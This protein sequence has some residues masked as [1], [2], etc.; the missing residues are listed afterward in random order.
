MNQTRVFLIFAWLMVA[1]LL[2]ME[3]GK[4]N[5]PRP[6]P[7][8]TPSAQVEATPSSS[9]NVPSATAAVET[10]ASGTAIPATT[11]AATA[12]SPR[13]V[14]STDV[15]RLTLDGG[16]V[17]EADLLN[18]P[19]SKAD[20]SPPV[21]LFSQ[22][23]AHF[24]AAQS[25]WVSPN[26]AAPNHL[27]G[28][29]AEHPGTDVVIADDGLQ[30]HRLARDLQVLV[31]DERGVGNGW[32]LPAGPLREALPAAVP[33]GS[34]VLYNADRPTTPLSGWTARRQLCGVVLLGDWWR[35]AKP[36]SGSL[37]TL[38]GRPLLA[39][40]GTA[41]PERFFGM[42]RAAGL[43]FDELPLPDHFDYAR[44]PWSDAAADV[45]VTEKDAVKLDPA[46][47]GATRIWVAALDFVPDPGFDAEVMR[48]LETPVATA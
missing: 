44:L 6:A 8:A 16:S 37:Q 13:V 17:L 27:S 1:T 43:T 15:L 7:A 28:F 35:G 32:L 39:A 41:R 5:A 46:R 34:I 30:H 22:D 31:F 40:A 2:W 24:Y 38:R 9:S 11:A 29:V 25:G 48:R 14:V 4:F 45:V 26:G 36:G 23:P 10:P 20:G 47:I 12:T 3:W 33:A 19:Q 42:L 21:K 18:Y